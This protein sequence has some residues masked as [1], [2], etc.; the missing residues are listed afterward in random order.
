MQE[1]IQSRSSD[2]P[3]LSAIIPL[4]K[5]AGKLE[6]FCSWVEN[7]DIFR[8]QVIVVHDIQDEETSVELKSILNRIVTDKICLIE[9][10]FHSPGLARNQGILKA[11]GDWITFWDS[12][13]LPNVREFFRAISM[14]SQDSVALVTGFQVV[15]YKTK[16]VLWR[17]ANFGSGNNFKA[18]ATFP[19]VWRMIFKR[20]I[21]QEKMF[22]HFHMAEDQF[23]LIENGVIN[24]NTAFYDGVTYSYF[25]DFPAQL[26]SQKEKIADLPEVIA[27]LIDLDKSQW[28]ELD[29]RL[30]A[31]IILTVLTKGSF[32]GKIF[33][34][35]LLPK[36][37]FTLGVKNSFL[38][39]SFQALQV[40]SEFTSLAK[41]GSGKILHVFKN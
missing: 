35:K 1:D 7:I 10:N 32:H 15:S 36:L 8:I 31:R 5:M 25:A 40:T 24:R 27:A 29:L 11:K 14:A 37:F 38:L 28:S 6:N 26:T 19:G 16:E 3:L 12:D 39:L 9:G 4:T 20:E 34:A 17:S 23:F 18:I 13:D 2:N 21:I 30:S 22:R 33:T 41:I